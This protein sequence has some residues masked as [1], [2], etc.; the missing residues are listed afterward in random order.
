MCLT[1]TLAFSFTC[2]YFTISNFR[3][4]LNDMASLANYGKSSFV[5]TSYNTYGMFFITFFVVY[6]YTWWLVL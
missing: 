1:L 3:I 6:G 2:K 5:Y 4:Q